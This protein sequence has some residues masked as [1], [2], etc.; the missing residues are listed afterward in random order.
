VWQDVNAFAARHMQLMVCGPMSD[1]LLL[2]LLLL[3]LQVC[4]P[5]CG[6]RA[7]GACAAHHRR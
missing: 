2:L 6:A 7:A 3:L 1:M 4:V 5:E